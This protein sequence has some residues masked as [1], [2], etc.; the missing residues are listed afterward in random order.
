MQTNPAGVGEE[1]TERKAKILHFCDSLQYHLSLDNLGRSDRH[2]DIV[3]LLEPLFEGLGIHTLFIKKNPKKARCNQNLK[4]LFILKLSPLLKKKNL[5]NTT[6]KPQTNKTIS[7]F[8]AITAP[9]T[10][11]RT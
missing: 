10:L 8:P 4:N 6:Q 9:V 11:P 2:P 1:Q 7:S 5:K 3:G